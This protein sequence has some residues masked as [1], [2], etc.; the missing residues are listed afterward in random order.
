[1]K[2]IRN[3]L[4]IIL[5]ALLAYVALNPPQQKQIEYAGPNLV[6]SNTLPL[7]V[8]PECK[9]YTLTDWRES[10]TV[11][12]GKGSLYPGHREGNEWVFDNPKQVEKPFR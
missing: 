12:G 4:I 11:F 10:P 8:C 9:N 5:L 2:T 1:M 3:L 7:P 6:P